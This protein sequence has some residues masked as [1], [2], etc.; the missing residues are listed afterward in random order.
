MTKVMTGEDRD[1]PLSRELL[2]LRKK[3]DRDAGLNEQDMKIRS[4]LLFSDVLTCP[5]VFIHGTEDQVV[6]FF[7]MREFLKRLRKEMGK[8]RKVISREVPTG[9]FISDAITWSE[10]LPFLERCFGETS[11]AYRKD[12]DEVRTR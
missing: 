4:P 8:G 7:Q 10:A 11:L 12:R 6:P 2:E 1:T 3:I 5:I 9:H